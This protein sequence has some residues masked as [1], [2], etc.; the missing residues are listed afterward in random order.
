MDRH[1]TDDM[2]LDQYHSDSSEEDAPLATAAPTCECQ[3]CAEV[4]SSIGHVCRGCGH[5]AYCSELHAAQD[6]KN[7]AIHCN[8][9]PVSPAEGA[10]T[11]AVEQEF[12]VE[13]PD[14]TTESEWI[15]LPML[16]VGQDQSIVDNVDL[17]AAIGAEATGLFDTKLTSDTGIP[18]GQEYTSG[19]VGGYVSVSSRGEERVHVY[20]EESLK[21]AHR[22]GT[23]KKDRSGTTVEFTREMMEASVGRDSTQNRLCVVPGESGAAVMGITLN[24]RVYQVWGRFNFQEDKY[25]DRAAGDSGFWQTLLSYGRRAASSSRRKAKR[26]VGRVT[27]ASER[28]RIKAMDASGVQVAAVFSRNRKAAIE[29]NPIFN[30]EKFAVHVPNSAQGE[31]ASGA[32]WKTALD[33]MGSDTSPGAQSAALSAP[34]VD[35]ESLEQVAGLLE[36]I[37]NVHTDVQAV[38]AELMHD[39]ADPKKVAEA[40]R[41][42]KRVARVRAT[43]E[44]HAQMLRDEELGQIEPENIDPLVE[45][46]IREAQDM[47]VGSNFFTR[48]VD[49]AKKNR[50]RRA[51]VKK[52][53]KKLGTLSDPDLVQ[54]LR[55]NVDS[56]QD[57]LDGGKE[58]TQYR[59]RIENAKTELDKM[60]RRSAR[61]SDEVRN[62]LRRYREA[63]EE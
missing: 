55:D 35:P 37:A 57:E 47:L 48:L 36:A 45:S 26:G 40:D 43:L 22:K 21:T 44:Q 59:N 7:H 8:L 62:L 28:V 29:K 25:K 18:G 31:A 24:G 53:K 32:T 38:R 56:L 30:F 61:R 6:W 19:I 46:C 16:H 42:L 34:I 20:V 33:V 5:A 3:G 52:E 13:G 63:A 12:Y 54:Y 14:G 17:C 50:D 27:G 49:R 60:E 11:W 58:G 41:H 9:A 2:S 10:A 1:Y 15:A 51:G 39:S 4:L 23:F